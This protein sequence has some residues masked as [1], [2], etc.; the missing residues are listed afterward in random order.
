M[1]LERER[2]KKE[3]EEEEEK[4]KC[5]GGGR[6]NW[7]ESSVFSPSSPKLNLPKLRRKYRERNSCSQ[8]TKL[9]SPLTC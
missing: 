6:E 2:G 4:R 8:M 3:E 5:L 7:W 9:P 1:I